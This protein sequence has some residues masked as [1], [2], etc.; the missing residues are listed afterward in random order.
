MAAWISSNR[1]GFASMPNEPAHSGTT[2]DVLIQ[3]ASRQATSSL[4]GPRS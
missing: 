3:R 1:T 4:T 2:R